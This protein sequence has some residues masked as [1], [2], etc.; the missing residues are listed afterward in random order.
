MAR[1]E[2]RE[3]LRQSLEQHKQ[4]LRLAVQDLGIAARSWSNPSESIRLHPGMW[5]LGA[6]AVGLWLGRGGR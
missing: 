1:P 5:L 6:F 4:E 3:V 2:E